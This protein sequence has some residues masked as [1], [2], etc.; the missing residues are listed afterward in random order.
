MSGVGQRRGTVEALLHP[1]P[2]DSQPAGSKET[3]SRSELLAMCRDLEKTRP[4]SN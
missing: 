4:S 3:G 2:D 1:V